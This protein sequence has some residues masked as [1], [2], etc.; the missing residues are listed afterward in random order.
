[1][2][3]FTEGTHA[4]EFLIYEDEAAFSRENAV[5]ASGEGK[6][7]AGTVLGKV[8]VGAAGVPAA[9]TNTGNPTFGAVT[10]NSKAKTGTYTVLFSATTKFN[11][12]DPD[13]NV[14]KQGTVGTAYSDDLGFT[15]T[16][17]GTPAVAGD[18]FTIAV[19]AGTAKYVASPATGGNGSEIASAI[20]LYPV[21]ATS[22]DVKVAIVARHAV[23][24]KNLLTYASSVDDSTKKAAKAAQL[25]TVGIIVR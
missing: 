8:G 9:G 12:V 21:D 19:A 17:G 1:M 20:L 10:V 6:L 5:I 11:L 7:A 2:T 23:V 14:Q 22:A 25:A 24:N 4:A 16:A 13:G 3:A 18:S 15:I